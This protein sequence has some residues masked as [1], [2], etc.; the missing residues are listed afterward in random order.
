MVNDIIADTLTRIRNAQ[1]VRKEFVDVLYSKVVEGIIKILKDNGFIKNYK[2]SAE[3]K[4][5]IRVYL[6]YDSSKEPV[7]KE[8]K[9]VSRP[10]LRKYTAAKLIKPYKNGLGIRILTTPKGIITDKE[11]KRENVGGEVLCEIW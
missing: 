4:G 6:K 5:F 8:I 9:R 1:M 3:G 10:G 11:A 7:I 2:T